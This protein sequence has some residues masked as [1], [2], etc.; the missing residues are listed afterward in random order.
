MQRRCADTSSVCST[1]LLV[2]AFLLL[3]AVSVPAAAADTGTVSGAVFDQAGQPVADATVRISGPQYPIGRDVL[4]GANGMYQFEYLL[5]GEYAIEIDKA[6]IG[7]ARRAAIVEV[8]RDTQVDVVLGLALTEEVTVT[9]ARPIVDVR[10]TEVSFNFNADTVNSLPLERTYRGLFQLIPGVAD[11]RSTLGP[12]AGGSR[13]DNTYLIDG[14]NITNPGF[15]YL[16]TE[17]N[18]LDIAEVNLKR[19]GISA[20][21]GRTSGTVTNA[22]SRSGSNR[23]SGFGRID[24]LPEDL[25]SAYRL[26]DELLDAGVRPG[27]FRDPLL[28]TEMGPAVGLGGPVVRN[29]MFFYGSARYFRQTKW[30]RVNKVSTPLPDEVAHGRRSSTASSRRLR[31]RAIS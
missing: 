13:Q 4:T 17:V 14:A 2:I 25:V 21:F 29:R 31:R 22:V 8:G 15:G 28:T 1:R 18:E 11:N 5:P 27:T 23:F 12:A 26:P 30:D 9:A 3:A 16:T 7:R 20:E 10:S 6:G 19:A 24:W